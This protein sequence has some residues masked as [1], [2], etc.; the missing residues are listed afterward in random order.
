MVGPLL[1]SR[2][3]C[4]ERGFGAGGTRELEAGG[5]SSLAGAVHK[6]Q[7]RHAAQIGRAADVRAPG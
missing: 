5:Q 6:E 7:T 4:Q 3:D 1:V 2:A